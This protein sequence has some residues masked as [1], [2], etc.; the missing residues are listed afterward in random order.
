MC[1]KTLDKNMQIGFHLGKFNI[2]VYKKL[3][4]FA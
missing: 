3:K 2:C 1:F 4:P